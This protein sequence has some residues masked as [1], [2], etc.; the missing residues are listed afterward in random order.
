MYRDCSIDEQQLS[1]YKSDEILYE[2]K[3]LRASFFR[4]G[5][6]AGCNLRF[7][8]T[9][10]IGNVLSW[11]DTDYSKRGIFIFDQNLYFKI[12]DIYKIGG[13]YQILISPDFL[14]GDLKDEVVSAARNDFMQTFN[15]PAVQVLDTPEWR[16]EVKRPLGDKHARLQH[17]LS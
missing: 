8:I 16:A 9:L 2:P 13:Y 15:S 17:Q 4:G 6:L 1:T 3:G 11:A 5:L 12:L 14:K 10:E 7:L